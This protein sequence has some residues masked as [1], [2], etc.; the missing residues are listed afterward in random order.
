MNIDPNGTF[1][2]T[3]LV[4]GAIVGA[5]IGFGVTVYQDYKD[6]GEV[7]NGSKSVLEYIGNI[8]GGAIAG[9]GVGISA[10]L[11]VS[12]GTAF[13][14]GSTITFGGSV[15]SAGTALT[16]SAGTSFIAGGVGYALRVGISD[17][18]SFEFSDFLI[19]STV[20]AISGVLS[21]AGG[22]LSG[23]LGY[24]SPV[25]KSNIMNTIKH[26]VLLT[27][28]GIYPN[29]IMLGLIEKYLKKEF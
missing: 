13:L 19:E 10:G 8:G 2:I 28:T 29:K 22:Y 20:N 5:G 11:G 15:I 12:A 3:A 1:F 4:V 7:F 24:R 21:F 27:V 16:I 26:H 9:A 25:V 23:T 18:E 17:K 14:T 6:D